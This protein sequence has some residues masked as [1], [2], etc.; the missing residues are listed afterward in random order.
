MWRNV[1]SLSFE[2]HLEQRKAYLHT[3]SELHSYSQ[4]LCFPREVG[5]DAAKVPSG[6]CSQME[7]FRNITQNIQCS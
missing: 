2:K 1:S 7:C 6:G 4:N 5:D 3:N